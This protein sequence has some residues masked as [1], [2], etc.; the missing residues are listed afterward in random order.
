M[1]N[2]RPHVGTTLIWVMFLIVLVDTTEWRVIKLRTD[3]NYL[4]ITVFIFH[5]SIL[6]KLQY[7]IINLIC[8]DQMSKVWF[9]RIWIKY[10]YS[11]DEYASKTV[12]IV[13]K[14]VSQWLWYDI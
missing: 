3:V 8:L 6:L 9:I 10:G 11:E 7:L 5:I 14:I 2:C 12:V 4:R 1:H 13:L